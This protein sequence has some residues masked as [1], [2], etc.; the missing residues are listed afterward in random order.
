M[1]PQAEQALGSSGASDG[2][3]SGLLGEKTNQQWGGPEDGDGL[4]GGRPQTAATRRH[5]L[6]AWLILSKNET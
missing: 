5:S 6:T 3:W 2:D 4:G 1:S